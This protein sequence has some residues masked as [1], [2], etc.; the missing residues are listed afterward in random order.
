VTAKHLAEIEKALQMCGAAVTGPSFMLRGISVRGEDERG[1]R[2][3][4][5]IDG[6]YDLTCCEQNETAEP[7][8]GRA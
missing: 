1:N 4:I 3:E 2:W 5:I 8:E 6:N 7:Y